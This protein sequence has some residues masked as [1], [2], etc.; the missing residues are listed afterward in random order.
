MGLPSRCQRSVLRV[1]SPRQQPLIKLTLLVLLL[2]VWLVGYHLPGIPNSTY[3]NDRVVQTLIDNVQ[4]GHHEV[5]LS[6]SL[7]EES[8]LEVTKTL[9]NNLYSTFKQMSTTDIAE[10]VLT[11][12]VSSEEQQKSQPHVGKSELLVVLIVNI[13]ITCESM[14][15]VLPHLDGVLSPKTIRIVPARPSLKEG[16]SLFLTCT[17]FDQQAMH[18][19][20][21]PYLNFELPEM[22]YS[23][24]SEVIVSY[25]NG[26][27]TDLVYEETGKV[28]QEYLWGFRI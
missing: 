14:I 24:E 9:N 27:S 19:K 28:Q 4:H 20:D 16:D 10:R 13:S 8:H 11:Q 25:I 23:L 17:V 1:L 5:K 12:V 18:N 2:T 6:R 26:R 21:A 22:S 3:R 7:N 15:E